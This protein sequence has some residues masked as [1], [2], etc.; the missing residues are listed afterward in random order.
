[1]PWGR[2][3][4]AEDALELRWE[5]ELKIAAAKTR[6]GCVV[7]VFQARNIKRVKTCSATIM[8]LSAEQN[9]RLKQVRAAP[10]AL[11]GQQSGGL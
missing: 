11:H 1:M 8:A 3:T 4:T 9:E 10:L 7:W 6:H 5:P 2:R